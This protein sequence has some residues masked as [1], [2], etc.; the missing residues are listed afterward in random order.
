MFLLNFKSNADAQEVYLKFIINFT[1]YMGHFC[2]LIFV[3][4]IK[5]I[6]TKVIMKSTIT[7]PSHSD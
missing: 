5:H 3:K 4:I 2:L 1:L 6:P 7:I